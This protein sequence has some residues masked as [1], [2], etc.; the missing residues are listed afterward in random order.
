MFVSFRAHLNNFGFVAAGA[1]EQHRPSILRRMQSQS[2]GMRAGQKAAEVA[3]SAT[4][5]P[6]AAL[7]AGSVPVLYGQILH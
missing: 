4:S 7:D 5:F 6:C 3:A 1:F 2:H